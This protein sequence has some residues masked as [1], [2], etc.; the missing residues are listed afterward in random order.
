MAPPV[1]VKL[2]RGHGVGVTQDRLDCFDV[3]TDGDEIHG[4]GVPEVVHP[5]LHLLSLFQHPCFVSGFLQV[6]GNQNAPA[7][8]SLPLVPN[9][10]ENPVVIA[11]IR[12]LT[13]PLFEMLGE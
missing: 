9:R 3:A 7:T 4:K 2:K 5:E 1:G 10:G 11:G 6:V 8:R 13:A 12:R